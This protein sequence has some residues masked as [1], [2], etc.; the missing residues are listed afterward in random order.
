MKA[1][2]LT[3][4]GKIVVQDT[5]R[6]SCGRGE[7]LIRVKLG[8][9]CGSDH[10]LYH[11]RFGVPLP[12]IPGHEAVGIV[13]K[14]GEGVTGLEA[15]Q[16]VTIQPNFSCGQCALCTSGHGNICPS[17]IRLGVDTNGVFAEFVKVPARY[18]W[19]IPNPVPDEVAVFTEPLS[20]G[21]HAMRITAP[22]PGEK[23]LIFGAGIMGLLILQL[24]V[25][26]GARV[27]AC[28]LAEKR[29]SLARQLGAEGVI[30]PDASHEDFT[31][32]FDVIY[33]TSGVPMALDRVIRMAA[34]L[35]KIVVLSLPGKDHAIPIDM[36]VRKELVI[37]GSLIYTDEFPE[38]LEILQSGKV[39][40]DPLATGKIALTDLDQILGAF[41]SPERVKT[42]VAI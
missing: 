23:V 4:V 37:R 20:V 28:D 41:A 6:P 34:P 7:V 32:T 16:R 11:G 33:E 19:K 39:K 17:K 42:L 21:V 26:K 3:E 25:S 8:G 30:G 12:V 13:E 35:G 22:N 10:T 31:N 18:V 9:I 1:A 15:G 5:E 38:A 29:L 27:T 40:T 36:V 2:I 24:A 14:T